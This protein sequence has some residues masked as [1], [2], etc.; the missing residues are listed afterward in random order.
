VPFAGVVVLLIAFLA[1]YNLIHVATHG[2][3]RYR[4]PALP[5]LF[6]LAGWT[7]ARWR[8]PSGEKP[9]AWRRGLGGLVLAWAAVLAASLAP[10]LRLM[11]R[12]G[13]LVSE[14]ARYAPGAGPEGTLAPSDEAGER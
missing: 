1:Y 5:V 7:L 6:V 8:R 11:T 3:A 4:L 13:A 14:N 12:P 10:S 2:Y 9:P